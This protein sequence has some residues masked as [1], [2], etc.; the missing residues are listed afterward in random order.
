[1]S[2]PEIAAGVVEHPELDAGPTAHPEL[3]V[4]EVK[5]RAMRGVGS[6]F[7][8]SLGQRGV[9]MVGNILLARWLDPKTIGL[10]AVVSMFIGFAGLIS[11]LGLSAS[12]VQRKNKLNEKDLRTGFTLNLLFNIVS[13]TAIWF[14][15]VPLANAYDAP[16]AVPGV[17]LLALTIMFSTF[18]FIPGIQLERRLKF[19]RITLADL[20]SQLSY[21]SV[22]VALAIPYWRNGPAFAERNAHGAVWVFIFATVASKLVHTV[23]MNTAYRW[24]P[25]IGVDRSSMRAMLAYGLPYQLNGIVN[26]MKD[27]FIPMFVALVAG[28]KA[29]GFIIWAAGLATNALFLLPIVQRVAFPAFARLQH[30]TEALRDAIE[31]AIKWVAATVIPTTFFMAALGRQ[32]VEHV[33][34]P[35]WF[36]GLPAFYLLCIPM[37]NAAY[38]TVMVSALYGTGRAKTVLRLTMIW[39]AA[40]WALG[41]PLTLVFNQYGYPLALCLVSCL[42]YMSVREM[43]KIVRVRFIPQMV[44]IAVLA[45]IPALPMAIFARLL[46]HNIFQ[47]AGVALA[48]GAI[49]LALM[50]LTGELDDV[51]QMI[52]SRERR[53]PIAEPAP[54]A[55]GQS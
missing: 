44:K 53:V 7:V 34:G 37:I 41:V 39:A 52:R 40:G 12:L 46:V 48:G 2:P 10:W 43:N 36:T 17:R 29:A 19:S 54:V 38:S 45:A 49:Y 23:I 35:K 8:R 18:T 13:V 24:R 11:D 4:D 55:G 26:W 50:A 15:A 1:M 51:K 33:Y 47:L 27:S 14:L 31:K 21:L 20:L 3:D 22:A 25:R 28:A 30:D 9:Q 5:R 6:M 32:I 16:S 42:S